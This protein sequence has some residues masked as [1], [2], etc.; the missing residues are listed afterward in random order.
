MSRPGALPRR[1]RWPARIEA[2]SPERGYACNSLPGIHLAS[3]TGIKAPCFSKPRAL[4]E[5]VAGIEFV[6]PA[7]WDECCGFGGTFSIFE[8]PVSVKMGQDKIAA[9]AHAGAEFVVSADS[10]C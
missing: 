5:K 1:R 4:L 2:A 10:S 6:E 7:R 9:H 3:P 8:P